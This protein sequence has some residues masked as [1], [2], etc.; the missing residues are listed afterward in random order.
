MYVLTE[1]GTPIRKAHTAA[2]AWGNDAVAGHPTNGTGICV[3]EDGRTLEVRDHGHGVDVWR[4]TQ[5]NNVSYFFGTARDLRRAYGWF[6]SADRLAW[7][8]EWE[9]VYN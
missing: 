8:G 4:V 3:F 7:G 6:S 1:N 9:V 2:E 5:G